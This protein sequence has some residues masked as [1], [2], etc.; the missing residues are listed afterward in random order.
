MS[1]PLQ[2]VLSAF[3]DGYES[4]A[5]IAAATGLD[6]SVVEAAVDHLVRT[7][8]R[9]GPAVERRLPIGRLRLVRLGVHLGWRGMW[10]ER[11]LSGSFR[12]RARG[13]TTGPDA[14]DPQRL[15]HLTTAGSGAGARAQARRVAPCSAR[16]TKGA[17]AVQSR[18][19]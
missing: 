3:D 17:G 11:A 16:V 2:R 13:P 9:A 10:R 18:S 14:A 1:G 7:G 12:T 5:A 19:A 8:P 6:R 15:P 4:L